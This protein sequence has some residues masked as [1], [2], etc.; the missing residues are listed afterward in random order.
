MSLGNPSD[1]PT[2]SA[3]DKRIPE[4]AQQLDPEGLKAYAH[5]LRMAI[6]RYLQD[7][8]AATSTSLAEHLGQSTGQTSY[9]L[10]QL[11]K[12]GLIE[13]VPG[14]GTGRERW[15]R[16]RSTGVDLATML[17]DDATVRAADVLLAE[18]LRDRTETLARWIGGLSRAVE[19]EDVAARALHS[20]S[21]LLLTPD[22]LAELSEALGET[23]T[24]FTSRHRSR[25]D[26][27]APEDAVRVRAYI[28]VFPLLEQ[29]GGTAPADDDDAPR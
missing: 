20:Q 5:P 22:E 11:A 9:H 15:W 13:D 18:M 14:R 28:D 4:S 12:H 19:N 17:T 21:T 27:G 3:P 10:R 26:D 2:S 29:G 25:F 16:A 7:V 23:I 6:L 8:G 1:P 24:Q